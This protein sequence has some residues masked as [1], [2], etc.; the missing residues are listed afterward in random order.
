[1]SGLLLT[2]MLLLSGVEG[3]TDFGIRT[4]PGEPNLIRDTAARLEE[5]AAVA[6]APNF[7]RFNLGSF[8]IHSAKGLA[9]R[10]GRV[11]S[12]FRTPQRNR[13]VGGALNSH[14]LSGK[15]IDIARYPGVRH[16]Q[17]EAAYRAAG[18]TLLESIDEGDH[19]HFAFA[20]ALPLQRTASALP[21]QERR[22]SLAGD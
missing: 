18:Y 21:R 15:A 1:M 20:G 5:K 17:I 4:V 22:S 11:T 9:S 16:A 14:H 7:S 3:A 13:A 2:T 19:S 6:S 8:D 10:W 12:T